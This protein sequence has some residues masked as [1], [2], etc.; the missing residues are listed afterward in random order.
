MW[1]S[2]G[3]IVK[4]KEQYREVAF[5]PDGD[6][7]F[8]TGREQAL[9]IGYPRA[10]L[11]RLPDEA[12]DAFVGVGNP[13]YLCLRKRRGSERGSPGIEPWIYRLGVPFSRRPERFW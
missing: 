3:S 8:H 2:T 1:T 13:F 9:R 11:D 7:H 6:F 10:A 5:N 12:T 4:V